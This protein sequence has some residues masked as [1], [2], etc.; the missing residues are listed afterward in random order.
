MPAASRPPLIALVDSN[1]LYIRLPSMNPQFLN[2]YQAELRKYQGA[3]IQKAVIDIRDNGG[4][5]DT[6]WTKLLS[7]LLDKEITIHARLAAKPSPLNEKRMAADPNSKA[8]YDAAKLERISFPSDE[9]FKVLDL[10]NI[11]SPESTSL[12][13][14][15]KIYVLSDHIYSSAGG[16]MSI[17]KEDSRLVSVGLPNHMILGLGGNPAAF[18][19]PNSKLVFTLEPEVDLTGAKSARDTQHIEVQATIHPTL[20]QLL[21]Y[22]NTGNEVSL[23]K[24][25][26]EHD[27]FFEKVLRMN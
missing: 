26:N 1:I 19:L 20:E 4:G 5:S 3:S 10:T 24:R 12:R 8:H 2:Y 14:H 22:Y 11:L 15:C 13:L 6:V 17:C 16:F 7:L 21:D 18:S 9:E 23:E 27:P 25:L